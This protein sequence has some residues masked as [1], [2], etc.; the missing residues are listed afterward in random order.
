MGDPETRHEMFAE[1]QHILAEDVGGV[2]LWHVTPADMWKPYVK[3]EQLEPDKFGVQAC[4][5]P[6]FESIGVTSYSVYISEEVSEY[7]ERSID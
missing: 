1:A 7:P 4:H 2:F 5:W 6:C 3:G